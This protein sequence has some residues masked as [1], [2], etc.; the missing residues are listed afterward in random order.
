M[1]LLSFLYFEWAKPITDDMVLYWL[2]NLRGFSLAFA[3]RVAR[4]LVRT[5]TFG[6][7][8]FQDFY[9]LAVAMSRRCPIRPAY[10]PHVAQSGPPVYAL[11]D[12]PGQPLWRDDD[13]RAPVI[14]IQGSERGGTREISTTERR[15]LADLRLVK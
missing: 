6:E 10:N 8:R 1:K 13:W 9:Q 2:T 15:L 4:Q 5:K 14:A 3:W 12:I 7:P 11:A